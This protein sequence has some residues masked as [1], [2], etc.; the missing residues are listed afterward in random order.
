[1]VMSA[2]AVDMTAAGKNEMKTAVLKPHEKAGFHR[3]AVADTQ[4]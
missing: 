2:Y 1:M 3:A 4:L